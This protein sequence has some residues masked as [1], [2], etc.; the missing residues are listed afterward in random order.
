MAVKSS[1]M[2]V[3]FMI[4]AVVAGCLL[5]PPFV[6][7]FFPKYTEGVLA[8]QVILGSSIFG[9]ATIGKL[10]I[11]SLKDFKM[12]AWYQILYCVF[13]LG[14]PVVGGWFGHHLGSSP[15]LGVSVGILISQALWIP[16]AGYLVYLA[17]H[18]P[19]LVA[20]AP[21]PK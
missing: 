14:G 1:L 18:K 20:P 10:A 21:T 11:W 16:V 4:P 12:M 3:A 19:C 9:G 13:L 7:H 6:S 17:T 2:V 15:L 8:A 5:L